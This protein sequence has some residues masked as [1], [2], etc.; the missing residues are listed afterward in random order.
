[1]NKI[2]IILGQTSTG[3]SDFAVEIAKMINGEIIGADSRQVYKGLDLGSGKIT[4]KEMHKIPHHLLDVI[5]P[6]KIF[7]VSKFQK[8]ANKKIIEIIKRGKIPIICGGTGFYLDSIA[9]NIIYPQVP[10]D[11]KLREKL[12]LKTELDLFKYLKQIDS[13][14]AKIIDPKNKIRLIRAIE[15]ARALGKVPLYKKIDRSDL[16]ILKIGLMIPNEELKRRIKQ[17]LL[18]R[19]KKGMINEVKNLH[20]INK[21]SWKRLESFGL[22]YRHVSLYLKDIKGKK[23]NEIK[24]IKEKMIENLNTTIWHFAKRQNTYFKRDKKIIWINPEENREKIKIKKILS[25]FLIKK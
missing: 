18:S 4:K 17:R 1:M 25:N 16:S 10:P 7:S 8:I 5:S 22:E 24:Q 23:Q 21:V 6:K 12:F 20:E 2:V 11:Y 14:R 9:N 19:I 13:R 3:K 15:I